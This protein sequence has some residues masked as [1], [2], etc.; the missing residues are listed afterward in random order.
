M[1]RIVHIPATVLRRAPGPTSGPAA[2]VALTSLVVLLL[3]AVLL[4]C[5]ACKEAV[6]GGAAGG[7]LARGFA[8]SI[9]L[10]LGAFVAFAALLVL[11]IVRASRRQEALLSESEPAS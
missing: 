11:L 2:L 3:P 7:S 6:D 9:Y 8:Q 5:P 4:A 1:R 10:M